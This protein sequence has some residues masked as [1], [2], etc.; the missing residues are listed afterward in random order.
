VVKRHHLAVGILL[1]TVVIA[2]CSGAGVTDTAGTE[3]GATTPTTTTPP[4]DGST[5]T[6]SPLN[7]TLRVHFI[8][9]GQSD[10]ILVE[11]PNQTLLM[12]TGDFTDDGEIVLEYLQQH[13]IQR[14]DYLVSSHADADHIR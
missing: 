14:L 11:A 13:D 9:V 8:N 1:I 12:D 4:S 2:G 10:A 6:T 3:T 7:G 5:V